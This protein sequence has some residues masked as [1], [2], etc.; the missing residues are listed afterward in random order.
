MRFD[1]LEGPEL[2][3]VGTVEEA[4]AGLGESTGP[5]EGALLEV[6][7]GVVA[8]MG[9]GGFGGTGT[10]G[11]LAAAVPLGASDFAVAAGFDGVSG[12]SGEENSSSVLPGAASEPPGTADG[13]GDGVVDKEG[14]EGRP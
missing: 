6:V 4:G 10:N 12:I 3:V 8:L 2:A 11:G 1:A 14:S 5:M 7:V 9:T 13:L